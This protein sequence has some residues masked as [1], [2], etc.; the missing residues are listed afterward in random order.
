MILGKNPERG[1]DWRS[2]VA[3]FGPLVALSETALVLALRDVAMDEWRRGAVP[4]NVAAALL[5]AGSRLLHR[6]RANS[7]RPDPTIAPPRF[8]RFAAMLGFGLLALGS[9]ELV[10]AFDRKGSSGGCFF[11]ALF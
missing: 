3:R 11:S 10:S 4:M 8:V 9:A 6:A 1:A 2:P 7:P 5:L